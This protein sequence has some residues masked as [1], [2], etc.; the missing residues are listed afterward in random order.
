M[1]DKRGPRQH[2]AANAPVGPPDL[3]GQP[4]LGWFIAEQR[5][6]GL[7][8]DIVNRQAAVQDPLLVR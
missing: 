7:L 1:A 2:A 4:Q 8:E 3:P 6:Q 5:E